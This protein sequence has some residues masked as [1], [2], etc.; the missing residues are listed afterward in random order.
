MNIEINI[1]I[2]KN[3]YSSDVES[4][5]TIEAV[6]LNRVALLRIVHALVDS[7]CEKFKIYK[8]TK[9]VPE[10]DL[11]DALPPMPPEESNVF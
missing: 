11:S 1:R 7:V 2:G 9:D 4:T 5:T 10:P 6:F 3:K 8:S